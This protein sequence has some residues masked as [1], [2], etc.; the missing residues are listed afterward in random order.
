[1]AAAAGD[2]NSDSAQSYRSPLLRSRQDDM[3]GRS[4]NGAGETPLAVLLGRVTGRRGASML[5]RETA[6]RQLE[7]RRADWGYSKPIVALDIMWNLAFVIVSVVMLLCTL[8]E[9]PN[10]PI[11][12]W[13]CGYAVQ[14]FVHSVLVWIEY[15]RRHGSRPGSRR[16]GWDEESQVGRALVNDEIDVEDDDGRT[17]ANRGR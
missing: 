13:I 12:V 1:M 2:L 5:V 11:R 3:G 17:G 4:R 16:I 10:S 8:H 15:T 9:K 14:C 7:E 6:A